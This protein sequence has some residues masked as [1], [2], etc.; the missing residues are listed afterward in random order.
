MTPNRPDDRGSLPR[1]S[2]TSKNL[3]KAVLMADVANRAHTLTLPHDVTAALVATHRSP[4]WN[5]RSSDVQRFV[6]GACT[7]YV[8]PYRRWA[9]RRQERLTVEWRRTHGRDGEQA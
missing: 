1:L 2:G 5:N 7:L 9:Y 8:V 6:V 4:G 3:P